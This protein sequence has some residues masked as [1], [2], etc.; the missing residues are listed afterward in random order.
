MT[1]VGH[2]KITELTVQCCCT[3]F[4]DKGGADD[5]GEPS[6]GHAGVVVAGHRA[7][8]RRPTA[9]QAV[10]P[11]AAHRLTDHDAKYHQPLRLPARHPLLHALRWYRQAPHY[12]Y[13]KPPWVW[14]G[15]VPRVTSDSWTS[16]LLATF[17]RGRRQE[18][19][20]D[21]QPTT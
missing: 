16:N 11:P 19:R 12:V 9:S 18:V 6:A 8:V 7:A 21:L 10:R 17:G 3:E 13:V 4:A 20:L 1:L 15:P 5:L 14:S 2:F